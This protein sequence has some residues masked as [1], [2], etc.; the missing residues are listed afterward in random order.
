MLH[1]TIDQILGQAANT[2][3]IYAKPFHWQ[4]LQVQ[5]KSGVD[6]CHA[7]VPLVGPRSTITFQRS[8]LGIWYEFET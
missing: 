8:S 5:H 2:T 1:V 6:R 7:T 3:T 4:E